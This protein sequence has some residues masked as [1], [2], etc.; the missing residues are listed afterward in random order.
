[1]KITVQ[2]KQYDRFRYW[3][4]R[5]KLAEERRTGPWKCSGCGRRYHRQTNC[6]GNLMVLRDGHPVGG[7]GA[8]PSV[9]YAVLTT[10][11]PIG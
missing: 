1:M 9:K 2:S 8:W 11:D 5:R 6:L 4:F 7:T 10:Y 3:R